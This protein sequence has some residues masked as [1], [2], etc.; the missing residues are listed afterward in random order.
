MGRSGCLSRSDLTADA[1]YAL[2]R[3]TFDAIPDHRVD[4]AIPLSDALMSAFAVFA[5][6]D[7]SRLAF[8]RRR[9]DPTDNFRTVFGLTHVPCDTQ[10]RDILDPV[11][12]AALRPCFRNLFRRLQRV[13]C[14]TGT[15]TSAA[16]T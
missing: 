14:S 1:L 10:M 4:P 7:P 5:L 2:I 12:P 16:A 15:G 11:D 8:D 13:R 9:D 3:Q 6:K